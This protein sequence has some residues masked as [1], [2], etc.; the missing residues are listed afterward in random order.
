MAV[1]WYDKE[2]SLKPPSALRLGNAGS[3]VLSLKSW[4]PAG[5]M[6]NKARDFG[7]CDRGATLR[8][9]GAGTPITMD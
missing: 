5:W 2:F 9:P 8:P 7:S 6:Q 1:I 4:E 3:A